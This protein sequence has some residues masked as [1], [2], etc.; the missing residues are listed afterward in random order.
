MNDFIPENR[1]IEFFRQDGKRFLDAH[2]Q[3]GKLFVAPGKGLYYELY[4]ADESTAPNGVLILCHG[5]TET[6]T[7]YHEMIYYF[8]RRGYHV[9]TCD[10]RGHGRSFR[11]V[12]NPHKIHAKDFDAEYVGDLH[13]LVHRVAKVAFPSLPLYLYGHS[14]GGCIAARY[15][16][17]HP[18]VFSRCI[19]SSPMFGIKTGG[20]PDILA[21]ALACFMKLVGLGH[22]YTIGQHDFYGDEVFEGSSTTSRARFDRYNNLRLET[23]EFMLGG[24][25]Y[26]WLH[27]ALKA[28]AR[29]VSKRETAKIK[30]PLLLFE[31]EDDAYVPRR[32]IRAFRKNLPSAEYHRWRGTKHEIY[33]SGDTV[34]RAYYREIF[35]FL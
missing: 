23:P 8:L 7:K 2:R 27:T 25:D 35:R 13:L 34:L 33:N 6:C 16:E 22:C 24:G 21:L 12:K 32:R 17:L 14:M 4:R 9:L 19:L 20:V 30:A 1:L 29:A 18:G 5:Y 28:A 3:T 31:A 15:M 10:H 11:E 26:S